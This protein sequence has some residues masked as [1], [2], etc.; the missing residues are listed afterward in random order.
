MSILTN[1]DELLQFR[2]K[3]LATLPASVGPAALFIFYLDE[4][5]T[6]VRMAHRKFLS[7]M[8]SSAWFIQGPPSTPDRPEIERVRQASA[9]AFLRLDVFCFNHKS[10][11]DGLH[12]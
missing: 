11:P 9:Y 4:L 6:D 5:R 7:Q 1:E 8:R 2:H 3:V 10:G 12:L